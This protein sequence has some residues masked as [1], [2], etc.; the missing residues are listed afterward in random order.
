MALIKKQ[1]FVL[2]KAYPQPSQKYEETVCCA[3]VTVDGEF[4]RLYPIRYRHLGEA[5]KFDRYDLLEVMGERPI[6]DHRPES[7]HV[8]E[9]SI[10]IIR[11]GTNLKPNQKASLWLKAVSPSLEQLRADNREREVSLGIV[12]PDEG[13]VRFSCKPASDSTKEDSAIAESLLHQSNLL[14]PPLQPL[15]P[16]EFGFYYRYLSNG[17]KS[18]GRIHD[19]EVQAAHR[20]FKRKYGSAA[21]E[22]LKT[23]YQSTI[24]SQNLHLLLGT[25]QA[26]PRQFIIIGLL[27]TTAPLEAL[28]AQGG[29]FD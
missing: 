15:P 24:P 23:M 9:N 16:P 17:K 19:W 14:D 20:E 10:R 8:D 13:S 5:A 3:G 4:V 7:F 21:M 11:R 26:H 27:R 22:H 12:K 25:M 28:K 18:E 29:L 1:V 2:V 6:Q